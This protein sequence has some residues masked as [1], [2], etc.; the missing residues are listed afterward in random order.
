M[1]LKKYKYG[2]HFVLTTSYKFQELILDKF[3]VIYE[4]LM[5]DGVKH[6]TKVLIYNYSFI[7]RIN[8]K[9]NF[10]K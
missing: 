1:H 8:P 7:Y 2:K 3:K 6:I 4:A 10:S 5:V 9:I